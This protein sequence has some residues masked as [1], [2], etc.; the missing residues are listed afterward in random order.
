[1]AS[2]NA[3][4]CRAASVKYPDLNPCAENSLGSNPAIA[5]RRLTIRLID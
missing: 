2:G 4:P 1:M 3:T 5:Q